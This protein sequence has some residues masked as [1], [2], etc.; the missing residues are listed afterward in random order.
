MQKTKKFKILWILLV[1]I[2]LGFLIGQIG[3]VIGS[4]YA[5]PIIPANELQ[6]TVQTENPGQTQS[7]RDEETVPV[8]PKFFENVKNVSPDDDPYIG[9]KDAILTIVEFTDYQCP[10]CGQYAE[11]TIMKIKQDYVDTGKVRYVVRDFPLAEHTQA[12]L[13]AKTAY[14]AAGQDKFWEM[15]DLLFRDQDS[16]SYNDDAEKTFNSYATQLG[17]EVNKFNTCLSGKDAEN[18][19]LKDISDAKIYGV[20]RIPTIFIGE[21]KIIGAQ[22]YETTF[23]PLIEQELAKIDAASGSITMETSSTGQTTGS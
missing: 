13:A 7:I 3:L 8:I 10:F 17:M 22:K 15:H 6:Q 1:G 4:R 9:S 21:K 18:E 12:F 19:I 23:K 20:S 14:C 5:P 2:L 11:D 16:W